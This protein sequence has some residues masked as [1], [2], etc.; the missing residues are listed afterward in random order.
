MR[1]L[2]RP[3][4]LLCFILGTQARLNAQQV[5]NLTNLPTETLGRA[6]L[7]DTGSVVYVVSSTNQFGTN[8][9][10]SPQIVRWDQAAGTGSQVTSFPEGVESVS[11]NDDG[12]WLAFTSCSNPTGFNHDGSAELFVMSSD[13]TGLAQLTDDPGTGAIYSALM[14]GSG[15]RVVFVANVDPLGTNAG[16]IDQIFVVNRDGSGLRQLTAAA[17]ETIY[18][19]SF[20]VSDDGER[21][22]FTH[23]GNLTGG[24]PAGW[25]QIFVVQA[26]GTG[27]RQLTFAT[28]GH[29]FEPVISGN[30]ARIAFR[31]YATLG[32]PSAT[33]RMVKIEWDGTG[34]LNLPPGYGPSI[35][36]DGQT[37]MYYTGGVSS[38]IWKVG[39]DG[40]GATQLTSGAVPNNYSALVSGDGS[41]IAFRSFGG[42]YPGGYNPDG[43]PELIVMDGSGGGLRQLT[44]LS[45]DGW[46]YA[47]EIIPD[48]TRVF[49][50][51]SS[52]PIGTNPDHSYEVFRIQ[53][54]GTGLAQVTSLVDHDVVQFSA[55]PDGSVV[56][57][58]TYSY[59]APCDYNIFKVNADGT[60]MTQLSHPT[61]CEISQW[62]VLRSDGQFVVFQSDLRL[63]TNSDG[64]PE[65]FRVRINGTSPSPITKDD[66]DYYK[67][68]RLSETTPAWIAYQSASNKDELN[69][70]GSLEIFR[71]KFDGTGLQRLTADPVYDSEDPDISGDAN[72]IVYDSAADPLGTNPDHNFEVFLYDVPSGSRRQ[73][74][75]TASGSSIS[76]RISKD[77]SWVYFLS[78]APFFEES[79]GSEPFRLSVATGVVER[80]GGTRCCGA[81]VDAGSF[82]QPDTISV[83]RTGTRAVFPGYGNWDFENPDRAGDL[84]LVDQAALTSLEIGRG[85]PTLLIWGPEPKPTRYDLIRGDTTNLRLGDGNTVDLGVVVC[86]ENDSVDTT[87]RG[88][89]DTAQPTA[90]HA[91]FYL[92]RGSQGTG[93]GPG[94]FGE[95]SGGR[96][97]I[98]GVGD[99]LP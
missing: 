66:D 29:C 98:V 53:A 71:I 37:I 16:H 96:E 14:S 41:R 31:S 89:E 81:Y 49:F 88:N 15:N 8:S 99:C 74:T 43:G 87:T 34:L 83:E 11:V 25:T 10:Y 68:P 39:A 63:G 6:S 72:R 92:Y 24:N 35:T 47:P 44:V 76:P 91:F 70:D 5:R 85:S 23:N 4:I 58:N 73:L 2:C 7:D 79:R 51:S 21:I 95:G 67:M 3:W 46:G 94:S 80:I 30:G 1:F 18:S 13:G 65:L 54:D 77:G 27:L 55:S 45:K 22:V 12:Q 69:P 75:F 50:L 60:G 86:L 33:N 48:G 42:Q 32:G 38:Q 84:F 57:F 40:S 9:T 90:G 97:R 78:D 82:R 17:T 36:D 64:S 62:P 19:L 52:D 93:D 20:S 59:S 56:V 28:D 61:G 26:D